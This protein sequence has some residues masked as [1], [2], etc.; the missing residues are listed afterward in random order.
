MPPTKHSLCQLPKQKNGKIRLNTS[1]SRL[2]VASIIATN[3]AEDLASPSRFAIFQWVFQQVRHQYAWD[4]SKA[5]EKRSHFEVD[6]YDN[7]EGGR[8]GS[9]PQSTLQAFQAVLIAGKKYSV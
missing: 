3:T 2:S 6:G 8:K 1:G 4:I 5:E 7:V 9:D